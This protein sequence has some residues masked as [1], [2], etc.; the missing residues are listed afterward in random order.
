MY[1]ETAKVS[2]AGPEDQSPAALAD[3]ESMVAEIG[4]TF[5]LM[6]YTAQADEADETEAMNAAILAGLVAP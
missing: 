4:V 1:G 5:P 6:A 2:H 3:L